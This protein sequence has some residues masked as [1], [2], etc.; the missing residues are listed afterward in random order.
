MKVRRRE[1]PKARIEIIPM[2]DVI[3]FLLVFFMVSSLAMTKI[4]S[5]QVQLPK[6]SRSSEALRQKVILSIRKDGALFLNRAPVT[7]ENLG[8]QLVYEMHE[9][10]D[11][12]VVVNADR[13]VSYHQ[14]VQ[15]MDA[16]RKVGVR[17]FSLATEAGNGS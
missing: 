5:I 2:I 14:V 8:R 11:E 3:F 9:A 7:L 16:A 17:R 1:L 4:N 10:P 6:T 12:A 15:A 13:E